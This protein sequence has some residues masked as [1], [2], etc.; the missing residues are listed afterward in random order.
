MPLCGKS[1]DMWW[2]AQR[3]HPVLGIELSQTA[4]EAFFTEANAPYQRRQAGVFQSFEGNG[5]SILCGDFFELTPL[6]LSDVAGVFDRGSL[7]ALPQEMR[8][9]Y[10][11]HLLTVL[12]LGAQILLLTIEYDQSVASGPPFAV[13]PNEVTALFG[14]ALRDRTAGALAGG[15]RCRRGSRRRASERRARARTGSSRSAEMPMADVNG[16]SLCYETH[17]DEQFANDRADPRSRHAADRVADRV[18]GRDSCAADCAW[19]CS[20]IAT[21]GSR[22]EMT[23]AD[24]AYRLEDMAGDVVGLMDHL[25]VERAHVFGISMGG[26]IAQH[27]AIGHAARVRSLISVMSS[28]GNPDL[29]QPSPEMRARLVESAESTEALIELNAKNRAVFGSPALSRIARRTS[30]GGAR[31]RTHAAFG[32]P[33]SRDRCGR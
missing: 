15:S 19:S 2:L 12:P 29:P 11:E 8:R 4:I 30:C 14:G 3:G 17:G 20:T 6:D 5:V 32:P 16:V 1:R 31:A 27:V 9:R 28:T 22:T 23:D 21:R 10:A 7:V 13:H 26:M 24:R 33:A 18:A 25:R